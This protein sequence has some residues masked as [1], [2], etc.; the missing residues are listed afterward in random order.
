MRR[1]PKARRPCGPSAPRRHGPTRGAKPTRPNALSITRLSREAKRNGETCD[2]LASV[3]KPKCALSPLF[4]HIAFGACAPHVR[5]PWALKTSLPRACWGALLR[6]VPF[7]I[8]ASAAPI[9]S[10][11][12]E[13]R[14]RAGSHA[15]A[16]APRGPRNQ[17]LNP[18]PPHPFSHKILSVAPAPRSKTFYPLSLSLKTMAEDEVAA[19]VV[20]NGSGTRS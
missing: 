1:S 13:A 10:T 9:A 5:P 2:S 19:L 14:A 18:A 17:G 15:A 12:R 16:P 8:A 3:H 11:A 6:R 20:D 7:R 4:D